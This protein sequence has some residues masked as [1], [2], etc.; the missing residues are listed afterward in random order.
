MQI[1]TIVPLFGWHFR[2][3]KSSRK[4][5]HIEKRC[6][7]IM[8]DNY[9]S[10]Y[11]TLLEKLKLSTVNVKRMRILTTEIFKTI[12]ELNPSLMK[13]IFT[14]KV[15]PKVWP[16]NLIVKRHNTTKYGTKR[17]ATLGPQIWKTLPKT[18]NLKHVTVNFRNMLT[19]GLG[20]IVTVITV[21]TISNK[22]WV[23]ISDKGNPCR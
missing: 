6:L 8:L 12:N 20:P 4:I 22:H 21:K 10:D 3:C 15:N 18:L 7:R 11:K 23:I 13:D 5:E 19:H 16:N 2:S 1:S 14:F 17:L 9:T